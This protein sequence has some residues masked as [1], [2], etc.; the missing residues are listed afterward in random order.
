MWRL[1]KTVLSQ[2]HPETID[3]AFRPSMRDRVFES[4]YDLIAL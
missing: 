2:S 3:P 1:I 4:G